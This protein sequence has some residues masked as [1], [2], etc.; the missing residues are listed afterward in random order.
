MRRIPVDPAAYRRWLRVWADLHD[1][2][3]TIDLVE[4]A[5]RH[6]FSRRQI[7]WVRRAGQA[8]LLNSATP[9]AVRMAQLATAGNH[10]QP[11][12]GVV[13]TAVG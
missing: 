12:N 9:P 7:Q 13:G 10:R 2:A 8:G 11:S 1:A 3:G 6:G 4:V 5:E